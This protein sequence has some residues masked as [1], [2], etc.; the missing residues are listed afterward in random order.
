MGVIPD[1]TP[2][3]YS[4]EEV[5]VP[6]FVPDTPAARQDIAAQYTTIGRMDQGIQLIMRELENN[7]YLNDTLIIFTS[8]NGIPFPVGRTNLYNS[9]T[10]V[11]FILSSPED[12]ARWGNVDYSLVTLLD[13]VPTVLDWFKLEFP[14]YTLQGHKVT[15]TGGSLLQAVVKR[16]IFKGT[17]GTSKDED[18]YLDPSMKRD[19]I[20]ASH[21][22]HEVTMYYPMRSLRCSRFHLIHNINFKMPFPIDQDFFVSPTFQDIL[23]RTRYKLPLHW[24]KTLKEYYYRDEWELYDLFADP[25]ETNNV[26]KLSLYSDVL[27]ALQKSLKHWL[28]ITADPWICA[29]EGVLEFQGLYKNNPQCLSLE[30]ML[31]NDSHDKNLNETFLIEAKLSNEN[32]CHSVSLFEILT[33]IGTLVLVFVYCSCIIV[34]ALFLIQINKTKHNYFYVE[35]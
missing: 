14:D 26:A 18:V 29:P 3:V 28:N 7:G 1:W 30:N 19:F 21:S 13:I 27:Q 16:N 4:P 5:V 8:D 2:T 12:T 10:A 25:D 24:F 23:K 22:L 6:Y 11:P 32:K 15:L 34:L 35:I 20:F 9:G 31:D 33:H 17:S